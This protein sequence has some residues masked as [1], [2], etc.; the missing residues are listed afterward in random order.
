MR[1]AALAPRFTASA[2]AV[3]VIALVAFGPAGPLAGDGDTTEMN[4]EVGQRAKAPDKDN[5]R[6]RRLPS[7]MKWLGPDGIAGRIR[8]VL[9]H[10]TDARIIYAGAAT[11]GVWKST[12]SGE[13]WVPLDDFMPSLVIGSLAM[14]PNDPDTIYAGTGEIFTFLAEGLWLRGQDRGQGIFVSRDAG[15][16]WR[17]LGATQ[18]ATEDWRFVSRIAIDPSSRDHILAATST[19]LW[20]STDGGDSFNRVLT[21]IFLDVK[22]HPIRPANVV[23][24]RFGGFTFF[25]KNFGSNWTASIPPA[26]MDLSD[27]RVELAP[28][29]QTPEQWRALT[30][31]MSLSDHTGLLTSNDGGQRF[32]ILGRP[33]G[34]TDCASSNRAYTGALW[35]DPHN[36]QR[37]LIGGTFLCKTTNGGATF[38]RIPAPEN[39]DFVDLHA[40]VAQPDSSD[41][42]LVGHDQGLKRV[43]GF[44]L[45]EPKVENLSGGLRTT[46]FQSAV[47]DPVTDNVLG[48]TQDTGG[49]LR[50]DGSWVKVIG[51]DGT[52][53]TRG[54]DI[55]YSGQSLGR[56]R[57][58]LPDGSNR[59]CFSATGSSPLAESHP[60]D[61]CGTAAVARFC[62]NV[63]PMMI[64]PN[65]INRLY[66]G[67][68]KLWLTLNARAESASDIGWS[69][70]ELS[71]A[72]AGTGNFVINTIDVARGNANLIWVGTMRIVSA[73]NTDVLPGGQ[74][75]KTANATAGVP[76]FDRM[77]DGHGLPARPVFDVAI[78]PRDHQKVY[79]SYSGFASD[80]VWKTADGGASFINI[81]AG[82]PAVPV[83][84]LAVHPTKAGWLYAGTDVGLYTSTDDGATW[85]AT[86]RGPATVPISD[87]QWKGDTTFLTIATYGRGTHEYDAS[88]NPELL[89]PEELSHVA[90]LFFSGHV[91]N[92]IASDN[93]R[94]AIAT[95]KGGGDTL[96]V[97]LTTRGGFT[98]A[99][100][101]FGSDLQFFIE[102][103]PSTNADQRLELFDF[104]SNQ[105]VTVQITPLPGSQERT[106]TRFVADA[107]SRFISPTTRE[108]QARITWTRNIGTTPWTVRLDSAGW[109]ITRP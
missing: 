35:V 94:Y 103:L 85:S 93:K 14:D 13:S 50:R 64:D 22:F 100:T 108:L 8:A 90:G 28:V 54:G 20:Q 84:S 38:V 89:F 31:D 4:Q 52:G 46:Q 53:A 48:G 86:S 98:R 32:F 24:S 51:G 3:S 58:M 60:D 68:R 92:L 6:L 105:F 65:D 25:S 59:F 47:A 16:T 5:R 21:G 107:A 62:G 97:V 19:G 91:E 36:A 77:D 57:R 10:P 83:W 37:M 81:S 95:P 56:V 11:G 42:I 78:D 75:W 106:T 55:F 1:S 41:G 99:A 82:L 43:L 101:P 17:A 63:T 27:T 88:P 33:K 96:S 69:P 70:I 87:L 45:L 34:D 74:L 9:I 80:N 66:V 44:P 71:P 18:T 79:V 72:Q 73:S 29:T 15:A 102:A 76:T 7:Q 30:I 49:L 2:I 26:G 104:S 40:I 39:V 12:D 23:A 61:R 109:R 67:C